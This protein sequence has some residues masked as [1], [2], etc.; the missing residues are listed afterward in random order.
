MQQNVII[1]TNREAALM[2]K[3]EQAFDKPG[4]PAQI[5]RYFVRV[6]KELTPDDI[7][8]TFDLTE[9]SRTKRPRERY[10]GKNDLVI[11]YAMKFGVNKCNNEEFNNS[12][13]VD[14]TYPDLVAFPEV[15]EASALEAVF[16]GT[17]S[18]KSDTYEAMVAY[19]MTENR[20]VPR[21]QL[22]DGATQASYGGAEDGFVP[23]TTSLIFSGQS[24]IEL[25]FLPAPKADVTAIGGS[26]ETTNVLFYQFKTFVIRNGAQ[27]ITQDNAGI[28]LADILKKGRF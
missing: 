19:S 11:F 23:L 21:T 5:Q 26:V 12:N 17:M 22:E 25:G 28:A 7:A 10:I 4:R 9:G 8:Q 2:A 6:E 16:N 24:A 20:V 3:L 14:Y 13:S 15:G 18:L 27:T 1:P